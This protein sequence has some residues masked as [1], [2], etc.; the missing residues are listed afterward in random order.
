[1]AWHLYRSVRAEQIDLGVGEDQ[2]PRQQSGE[3]AHHLQ[4]DLGME[5]AV[6]GE[7]VERQLEA[8][9]LGIGPD[10]GAASV[11]DEWPSR[12]T[13]CRVRA[14]PDARRSAA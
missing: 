9:D 7:G 10:I 1:M 12:R 5:L 3:I 8:F 6:I 13:P 11:L 14:K 4:R 2:A